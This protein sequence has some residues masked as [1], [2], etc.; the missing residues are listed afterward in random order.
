MRAYQVFGR[1]SDEEAARFLAMLAEKSPAYH[2]QALGAAAA[3]MRA[4]PQYL[5]R[6]PHEKRAQAMRRALARV[7]AN[8]VAEELLAVYF[9]DC[10]KE[11]LVEWLDAVGLEHQEGTL[12]ADAPPCPEAGKLAA[13][14]KGFRSA[15]GDDGAPGDRAERELLLRAFAA[16]SAVDWPALDKLLE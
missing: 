1:M 11:L 10:R 4:R 9:L 3:A 8:V 16:Q 5:M 14:L 12:K 7:A 13:S 2:V 6:Q 15:A